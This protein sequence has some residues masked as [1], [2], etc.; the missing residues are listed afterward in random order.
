MQFIPEEPSTAVG[1]A[2]NH[3][4]EYYGGP[5]YTREYK[6]VQH[7][8]HPTYTS[9]SGPSG[10]LTSFYGVLEE[11]LPKSVSC[12][13]M[14]EDRAPDALPRAT[15]ALYKSGKTPFGELYRP[16][17]SRLVVRHDELKAKGGLSKLMEIESQYAR[18]DP[19]RQNEAEPEER[20]R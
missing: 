4:A 14:P 12:E 18:F 15:V 8:R 6:V 20:L 5:D 9:F 16:G 2:L 7:L 3:V 10:P 11:H 13:T 1:R 19:A 17:T